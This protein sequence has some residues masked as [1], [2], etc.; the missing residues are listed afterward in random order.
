MKI[1][2]KWQYDTC[3]SRIVAKDKDGLQAVV[4]DPV[5]LRRGLAIVKKANRFIRIKNIILHKPGG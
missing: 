1:L 5:E 2:P 3:W 4:M